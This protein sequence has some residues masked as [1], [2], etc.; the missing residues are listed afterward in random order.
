MVEMTSYHGP[1][2]VSVYTQCD[3][4]RLTTWLGRSCLFRGEVSV[5]G[6]MPSDF[7]DESSLWKKLWKSKAPGKMKITVWRFA[8]DCLPSGYQLLRRR[9]PAA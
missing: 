8:H 3:G 5:G 4:D 7:S 6:G 2:L 1:M 9:V